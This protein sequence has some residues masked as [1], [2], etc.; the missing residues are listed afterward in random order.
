MWLLR[1]SPALLTDLYELTMAQVYFNEGLNDKAYFEIVTRSLPPNWGYFVLAGLAE[2]NSFLEEFCFSDEDITYLKSLGLFSEKF[3]EYLSNLKLRVSVRSLPEGTVF[4]PNEPV[5]EVGGPLIHAQI[6]ESCILNILGF[7]VIE[8]TLAAR[9]TTAS[10]S[11]PVVDFGLRRTQ[12]PV[13]SIRAARGAQIAGFNATSN[14]I[15]AKLLDFTPSGT[16]AHS[17]IEVH[18]TEINAFENFIDH[19]GESAILLIDTYDPI[20]GIKKTAGI[21]RRYYEQKGLK[22]KGIRIDSGDFV[23]LSKFARE[24]FKETGVGFLKIFISSGLDE[25][26]IAQLIDDG[27]EADGFG[28]GTRYAVSHN[29]PD[30]DIVYKI[31]EYAGKGLYKT[32]PDKHTTPGRKTILR[33]GHKKYRK[34]TIIPYRQHPG[35]L[36]KSFKSPEPVETIQKRLSQEL[37]NLPDAVKAI[38]NPQSYNVEFAF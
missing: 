38:E 2:M 8:A 28:V 21:A 7:S 14:V 33:S 6:L 29:A 9:I 31:T 18:E 11:W 16:M 24:H 35:D 34:D 30:L 27:A 15:A 26:R 1:N 25:F 37:D 36:L 4:F 32:S 12:G 13:A 17:Y 3:L 10:K 20:E 22:I 19:Y 23:E 5:L